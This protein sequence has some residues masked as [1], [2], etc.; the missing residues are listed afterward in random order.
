MTELTGDEV[1]GAGTGM[2]GLTN[3]RR[4]GIWG[5]ALKRQELK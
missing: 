4:L 3:Q 5:G 2:C 1:I